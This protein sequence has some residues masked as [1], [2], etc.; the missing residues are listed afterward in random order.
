MPDKRL[1][2]PTSL[3]KNRTEMGKSL[4]DLQFT[5][6]STS[7]TVMALNLHVQGNRTQWQPGKLTEI[8]EKWNL[9]SYYVDMYIWW[10]SVTKST[11]PGI[12][13]VVMQFFKH[14]AYPVYVT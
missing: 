4:E 1:R 10:H 11:A 2:V 3:W 13:A 7:S 5:L 8:F 6:I 14:C 12:D 9:T